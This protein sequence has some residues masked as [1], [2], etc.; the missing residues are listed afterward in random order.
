M[1]ANNMIIINRK[2]YVVE[3]VDVETGYGREVGQ[4]K[5]IEE[6][7]DIAQKELDEGDVEY[8]IHFVKS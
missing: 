6:A 5:N 4:G 3:E 1:S 8:G 2:T 7:I